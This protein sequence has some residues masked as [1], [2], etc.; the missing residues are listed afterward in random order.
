MIISW[1]DRISQLW[2]HCNNTSTYTRFLW[3]IRGNCHGRVLRLKYEVWTWIEDVGESSRERMSEWYVAWW[4]WLWWRENSDRW[5]FEEI[6][7][8]LWN[9]DRS[10]T[11]SESCIYMMMMMTAF[12]K[13]NKRIMYINMCIARDNGKK[14]LGFRYRSQTSVIRSSTKEVNKVESRSVLP[15]KWIWFLTNEIILKKVYP[16]FEY[17]YLI[18]WK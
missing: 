13:R 10:W 7:W 17:S 15:K 3:Q 11:K 4:D 9:D 1:Y 2:L 16:S 6:H 12:S 8:W 5:V 18:R 14:Y